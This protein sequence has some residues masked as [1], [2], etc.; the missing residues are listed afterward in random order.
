[1]GIKIGEIIEKERINKNISKIKLAKMVG[2]TTRAIDYWE[3]D[4]RSIS[5]ENAD[6][7]FKALGTTVTIG[8][9][10]EQ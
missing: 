4:K 10:R 5:L 6:K 1:M 9:E 3:S 7:I 2:C 8:A